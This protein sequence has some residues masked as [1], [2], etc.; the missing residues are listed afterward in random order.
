MFQSDCITFLK[1]GKSDS[2]RL[3]HFLKYG[4]VIRQTASIFTILLKRS[5][6][7]TTFLKQATDALFLILGD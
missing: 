3:H 4:K 7:T 1:Y 5:S 2:V 6:Q